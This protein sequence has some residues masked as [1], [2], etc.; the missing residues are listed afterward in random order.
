MK[1]YF[2]SDEEQSKKV[3]NL[4]KEDE[5]FKKPN[6][7]IAKYPCRIAVYDDLLSTPRIITIEAQ[8]TA[9]YLDRFKL[10]HIKLLLK[11]L[12]ALFHLWSFV[13]LLK[14]SFMPHL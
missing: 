3:E 14:I 4:E 9:A 2:S 12:V 7:S 6:Y 13:S 10:K 11:I 1:N 5:N 8:E